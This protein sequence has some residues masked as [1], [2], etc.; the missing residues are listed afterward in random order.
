MFYKLFPA[1]P[2]FLSSTAKE[3]LTETDLS[4]ETG[5]LSWPRVM[6]YQYNNQWG[7]KIMTPLPPK[8]E[9]N[10]CVHVLNIEAW[11][12]LCKTGWAYDQRHTGRVF[13]VVDNR[14]APGA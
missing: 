3:L 10:Y 5:R 12:Y 8:N 4:E 7:E 6:K 2:D 14:K 11:E 1:L 9:E 13:S